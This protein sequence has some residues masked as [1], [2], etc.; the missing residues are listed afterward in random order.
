MVPAAIDEA[1]HP[2]EAPRPYV[3]RVCRRKAEAGEIAEF[4]GVSSPYEAPDQPE[5]VLETDLHA[6]DELV[7]RVRAHL[8]E[9]GIAD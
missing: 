4:T 8:R 3:E 7:A 2:G 9:R 5:L 6:V 1:V